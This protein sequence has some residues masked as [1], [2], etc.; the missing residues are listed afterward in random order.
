MLSR[1]DS[2]IKEKI[3]KLRRLLWLEKKEEDSFYTKQFRGLSLPKIRLAAKDGICWYPVIFEKRITDADDMIKVSF[4]LPQ[5]IEDEHAFQPGSSVKIFHANNQTGSI[6]HFTE[7]TID[8]I[9]R[10]KVEVSY[11]A[12]KPLLWLEQE[13]GIGIHLSFNKYTYS[14]MEKTL[15]DIYKAK[16]NRLE[17]LRDIMMGKQ[18]ACF[19]SCNPYKSE[20]LNLSQQTAV[21]HILSS[22]D[23][24][25]VHGPPGTGKTTTLVEA[26]IE[27]LKTETQIM[28]CAYNNI[29][30]DVI[31][32]KLMMRGVSVVRIGNPARVTDELLKVTYETKFCEHPHYTDMLSCKKKIKQLKSEY[33]KTSSRD[34]K[35]R[36]KIKIEI[37]ELNYCT[38]ILELNIKSSIFKESKVVAATMIGAANKILKDVS[39]STVFIDEAA[40]ALEPACWT[41]ITKALRVIFAGDHRQLPPTVKSYEAAQAGLMHTLFEKII[42]RSPECATLLTTQYRMHESIMNFS[43]QWFYESHLLA[44]VTV[45]NKTL[46]ENDIPVVWMDTAQCDFHEKRELNGTSIYNSEEADLLFLTLFD[47]MEKMGETRILAEKITF[48]LISPYSAQIDL[49][50]K[51]IK[52]NWY[53]EK[54]LADKLISI[55]TVDGFQGQEREVIAIS[56]VRSNRNF[57]I[58]FLA[59][60]RRINVAMT[61]AR[62]KLFLIGDSSTLREDPFFEDL[63]LYVQK[64]GLVTEHSP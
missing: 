53:F 8:I 18:K 64:N 38:S 3:E 17:Q 5:D 6:I 56:L 22:Q 21:N 50:R 41:P 12:K 42:V 40:Q 54:F 14:V 48:G 30:V 26:I 27:T 39:F 63:F 11:P 15:D 60:Y 33:R 55:R 59:D 1:M 7:G 23:I 43:S 35:S 58:G 29:A 19:I 36:N 25:L 28:V 2:K 24:A 61:R 34:V 62:K 37:Y 44:S 57:Q 20:W 31:A 51:K 10:R 45:K 16:D 9:Y 47:Y 52:E 46:V 13:E 4:Q 49:I 32:E